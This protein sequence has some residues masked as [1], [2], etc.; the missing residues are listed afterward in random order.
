M[1]SMVYDKGMGPCNNEGVYTYISQGSH[2]GLCQTTQ[3]CLLRL[4]HSMRVW[5]Q[6]YCIL[7]L[8]LK[9]GCF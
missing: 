6:G 8:L 5:L 2:L 4:E 9:F 3:K 1:V 7:C